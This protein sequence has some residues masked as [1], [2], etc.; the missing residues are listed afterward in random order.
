ML[1]IFIIF[2]ATMVIFC[3]SLLYIIISLILVILG[4][5]LILFLLKVEFL[6]FLLLLIYIG[7]IT[8]LFIFVI[9]ML[10]LN[11]LELNNYKIIRFFIY[12]L[13][14]ML[15]IIKLHF[16]LCYFNKHFCIII[17]FMTYEYFILN[18][19]K[20]LLLLGDSFVFLNL[21]TQNVY[22]FLLVGIILLFSMVG[23]IALC[24]Q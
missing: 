14:Y 20:N 10:K 3:N 18:Q 17:D 19:T 15:F 22:C 16:Y 6:S 9:M 23:S 5:C 21:F 1:I 13:I 8:I 2:F 11:Q 4:S 7:A 12:S 24:I